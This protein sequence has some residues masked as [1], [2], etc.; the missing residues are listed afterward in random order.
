MGKRLDHEECGGKLTIEV[1]EGGK[2]YCHKCSKMVKGGGGLFVEKEYVPS[3][4]LDGHWNGC[5]LPGGITTYHLTKGIR[6]HVGPARPKDGHGNVLAVPIFAKS[7]KLQSLQLIG[8]DGTKRFYKDGRVKGGFCII[9][10][11]CATVTK[12]TTNVV[13]VCEG[14]SSSLSAFQIFGKDVICTFNAGNISNVV[15]HFP[16]TRMII[17]ADNDIKS[18]TGLIMANKAAKGRDNVSIIMTP[19]PGFDINDYVQKYGI[20]HTR[21]IYAELIRSENYE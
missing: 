5:G 14:Y 20:E 1:Y 15:A 7:G 6:T 4:V 18:Q 17:L 10:A 9:T 21:K 16:K 11:G 3:S 8:S 19:E 2:H 13:F 12:P